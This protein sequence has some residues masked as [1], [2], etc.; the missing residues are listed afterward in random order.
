MDEEAQ[1]MSDAGKDADGASTVGIGKELQR[2]SNFSRR[3][4]L[5]YGALSTATVAAAA[6]SVGGTSS[7]SSGAGGLSI[8]ALPS[9]SRLSSILSKKKLVVGIESGV[10]NQA[11]RDP[12]GKLVG[13]FVDVVQ[14][15]ADGLGVALEVVDMPFSGIIPAI[16]AG[17]VDIG[18]SGITNTP[19]RALSIFF[20]NPYNPSLNVLMV[21]KN[22]KLASYDDYNKPTV[23]LCA[24]QGTTQAET[25]AFVFPKA[26]VNL[27]PDTNATGLEVASGRAAGS[28]EDASVVLDL[29]K[30][31]P[32]LDFYDVKNPLGF[33]YGAYGM[34]YGDFYFQ[35]WINEWMRYWASRDWF[36]QS[37]KRWYKDTIPP[38]LLAQFSIPRY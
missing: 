11:I 22:K 8:G 7:N 30:G 37:F 32:A 29:I 35:S 9:D 4:F 27:F 34:Q 19:K 12:S 3:K 28:V 2:V 1:P 17:K 20:S 18:S 26:K 5:T 24:K 25:L 13:Y 21:L 23:T 16:I 38:E 15:M 33:E 36:N 10:V 14:H 6:C 31:N